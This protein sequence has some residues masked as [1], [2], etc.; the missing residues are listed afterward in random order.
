[1]LVAEIVY[2]VPLI[3]SVSGQ[4]QEHDN[5]IRLLTRF[6]RLMKQIQPL[7]Q[8]VPSSHSHIWAVSRKI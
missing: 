8:K 7:K 1:L 3:Y 6:W 4:Q 5:W 2:E